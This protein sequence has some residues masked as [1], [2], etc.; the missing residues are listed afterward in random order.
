[1]FCDVAVVSQYLTVVSRVAVVPRN[2][3]VLSCIAVVSYAAV[4]VDLTRDVAVAVQ[5][6]LQVVVRDV[7]AVVVQ[8]A[9]VAVV[10][11]VASVYFVVVSF[12]VA[13]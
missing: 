2:D 5:V 3:A 10:S 8:E 12:I 4:F 9:C 13:V 1:M 11:D 7:V 6:A